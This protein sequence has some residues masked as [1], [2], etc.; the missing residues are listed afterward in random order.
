[1]QEAALGSM[2]AFLVEQ[3]A[4]LTACV[5]QTRRLLR[6]CG[7][8]GNVAYQLGCLNLLHR[9][10]RD[11]LQYGRGVVESLQHADD[12]SVAAVTELLE[13]FKTS[14][15]PTPTLRSRGGS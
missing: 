10:H 2:D 7:E 5:Q 12:G 8:T 9:L 13:A 14:P 1:V 15:L 4:S 6:V 3:I 11:L